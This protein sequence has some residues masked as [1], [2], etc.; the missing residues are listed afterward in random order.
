[1]R[2]RKA[3]SSYRLLARTTGSGFPHRA[4]HRASGCG[5]GGR[6]GLALIDR[7]CGQVTR[8]A[9]FWESGPRWLP[10]Q[11][12]GRPGS[13][14]GLISPGTKLQGRGL[15][16]R[17]RATRRREREAVP[18]CGFHGSGA[19]LALPEK[20]APFPGWRADQAALHPRSPTKGPAAAGE[21][22]EEEPEPEPRAA[23]AHKV[24]ESPFPGGEEPAVQGAG[25]LP[26][27]AEEEPR[28]PS[29]D[30]AT[31][32]S[33]APFLSGHSCRRKTPERARL[34]LA[35]GL[36]CFWRNYPAGRL[37]KSGG[38][39]NWV[40]SFFFAPLSDLVWLS[41]FHLKN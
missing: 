29:V 2:A 39:S 26:P 27:R 10:R 30:R 21:D 18:I 13:R 41:T 22:L 36:F 6:L 4:P 1:M 20:R 9:T 24:V 34:C 5:L 28:A 32:A 16:A 14:E 17:E 7:A 12:Q 40:S 38:V 23:F 15:W 37:H 19:G 3:Y 11:G 25:F 33:G 31:S 35:F 8:G